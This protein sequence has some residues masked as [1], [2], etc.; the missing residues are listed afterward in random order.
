MAIPLTVQNEFEHPHCSRTNL[1]PYLGVVCLLCLEKQPFRHYSCGAIDVFYLEMNMIRELF[2]GVGQLLGRVLC[3][4]LHL[5]GEMASRQ[6]DAKLL[7]RALRLCDEVADSLRRRSKKISTE[8][9]SK[10]PLTRT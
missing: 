3:L 6:L 2:Q 10:Q 1:R 5:M 8:Q 7:G 4:D 9:S